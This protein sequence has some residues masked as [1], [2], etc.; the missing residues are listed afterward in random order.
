MSLDC[1]TSLAP[2]E[3]RSM[4]AIIV[5]SRRPFVSYVAVIV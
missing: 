3:A 4:P 5:A 1:N 2:F